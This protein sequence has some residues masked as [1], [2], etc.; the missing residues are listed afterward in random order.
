MV[1]RLLMTMVMLSSL[2]R[3]LLHSKEQ[4]ILTTV[5]LA[6]AVGLGL[7]AAAVPAGDQD[8][9][10]AFGE[11][12]GVLFQT[13]DDIL[14]ADGVVEE[15]GAEAARGRADDAAARA[16]ARLEA[17]PADTAVLRELVDRL[18]ERTV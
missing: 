5:L 10:R 14:D 1:L 18:A 15:L 8:P 17:L 2:F 4:L 16:R 11:E 6:A 9:W 7:W 12:L 3:I 13:V